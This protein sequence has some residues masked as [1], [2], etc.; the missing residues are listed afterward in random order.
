MLR[1]LENL[2]NG[3]LALVGIICG[4]VAPGKPAAMT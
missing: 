1:S 4:F 2:P 3:V